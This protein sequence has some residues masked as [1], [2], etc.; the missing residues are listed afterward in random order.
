MGAKLNAQQSMA[1]TFTALRSPW[2]GPNNSQSH[3]QGWQLTCIE[4]DAKVAQTAKIV[5]DHAKSQI[6]SEEIKACLN[7][8]SFFVIK[9]KPLDFLTFLFQ[10]NHPCE[11]SSFDDILACRPVLV[12]SLIDNSIA[13]LLSLGKQWSLSVEGNKCTA[14]KLAVGAQ[15]AE[16]L[17]LIQE[18]SDLAI[19]QKDGEVVIEGDVKEV[20]EFINSLAAPESEL[21]KSGAALQ[22]S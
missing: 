10:G 6:D 8:L 5:L 2:N 7:S 18:D 9:S 19:K 3:Y 16:L 4:L 21:A 17:K 13:Y 11:K 14:R 20:K 12:K 1:S 15:D 22:S